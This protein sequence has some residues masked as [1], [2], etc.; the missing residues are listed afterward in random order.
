M[1]APGALGSEVG[2][3]VSARAS[4]AL[5]ERGA[6]GFLLRAPHGTGHRRQVSQIVRS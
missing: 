5:L 4:Q 6:H 1:P 2:A 3:L